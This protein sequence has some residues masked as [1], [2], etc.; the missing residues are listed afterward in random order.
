MK[1]MRERHEKERDAFKAKYGMDR[2][3]KEGRGGRGGREGKEERG[4]KDD[5]R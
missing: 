1:A 2:E 4:S 3:G 5:R